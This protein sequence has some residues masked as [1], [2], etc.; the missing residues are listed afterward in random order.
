MLEGF[1]FL[2]P[3]CSIQEASQRYVGGRRGGQGG[4]QL[5]PGGVCAAMEV[6]TRLF[7][8]RDHLFPENHNHASSPNAGE[9]N[10]S[11]T[12]DATV[13]KFDGFLAECSL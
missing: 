10:T 13:S 12:L 11:P 2:T 8:V 9:T 7:V 1:K 3:D 6:F 4:T 5:A